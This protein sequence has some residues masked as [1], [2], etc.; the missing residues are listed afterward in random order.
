MNQEKIGKFISTMRKKKDLTQEQLAEKLNVSKNAV[1]KWERG[2]NLP[3]ASIM[4]DVCSIL[5]ISLNELFAGEKLNKDEQIKHSEQTIINILKNQ[6]HRNKIYKICLSI[7]IVVVLI[8]I[9]RFTLIKMGYIMD[10]N[11]KYTQVYI[12]EYGNVKGNVDINS[13]GKKNIAF[14]I[15]ANKYG[16]AVFKNPS[17]ALKVLKRDYKDGIK[18]IQKEFNLL[19]LNR[20][21]YKSY[22]KLAGMKE[23]ELRPLIAQLISDG[24]IIQTQDEYSV[25][26][27]GDITPLKQENAHIYLKRMKESEEVKNA[28]LVGKTRSTGSSYEAGDETFLSGSGKKGRKQTGKAGKRSSSSTGK[29][30]TDSLTSA[31]YELFERLKALRMIIAREE[32]MP[33][34]IVFS[35]K[36]LIDM[37]EKL[38]LNAEAMLEVS[39]VGQNK[40]MKYG[41]RFVNEIDTFVKEHKGMA[42]TI[43]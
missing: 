34:Y 40:L 29:K 5:D 7:L 35:D 25:L 13:F 23:A 12:A 11:L 43:N 2:L 18:L 32:G 17:K 8:I 28:K 30:S 26:K 20:F 19:P 27:M 10:D 41:Q 3:D 38:P 16:E 15:G 37:C 14:D 6:K 42:A 4:Q 39:G 1:S 21:N 24:Y 36:T 9:G 31:G 33:P 22:G